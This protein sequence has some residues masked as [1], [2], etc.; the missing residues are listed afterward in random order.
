MDKSEMYVKM[1]DYP[2][3][4]DG[5]KVSCGDWYMYY[6]DPTSFDDLVHGFYGEW[7]LQI[8]GRD[9]EQNLG[10]IQRDSEKRIWLRRQDQLQ[11]MFKTKLGSTYTA[12]ALTDKLRH[13][14]KHFLPYPQLTLFQFSMEQ[15]WL[16]FV[17]HELHRK[18]WDGEKWIK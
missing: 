12:I 5:W 16:A 8:L 4:Q 13:W 15:L 3:I 2:E 7:K 17:M 11:G 18:R 9:D 10:I 14:V 1:S 6:D